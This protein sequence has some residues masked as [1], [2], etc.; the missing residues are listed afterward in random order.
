MTASVSL[1][2][3]Q[4]GLRDPPRTGQT[5]HPPDGFQC[6]SQVLGRAGVLG[7]QTA[8]CELVGTHD[9]PAMRDLHR[10]RISVGLPT[11]L[12]L[13]ALLC[14]VQL[15]ALYGYALPYAGLYNCSIDT[16]ALLKPSSPRGSSTN[17]HS[18]PLSSSATSASSTATRKRQ[19][20]FPPWQA[21]ETQRAQMRRFFKCAARPAF[22]PAGE[23]TATAGPQ[24]RQEL[25]LGA[26]N[27]WGS[28]AEQ[29]H[30]G[31]RCERGARVDGGR[32]A[33]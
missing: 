17:R 12:S 16:S 20:L 24:T 2:T 5:A 31:E 28:P 4:Q 19:A 6:I 18:T 7:K 26:T 30:D 9:T 22:S 23:D 15:A 21:S 32:R 8:R 14:A 29:A 10:R 25:P 13:N 33:V 27:A 3:C 1:L 11:L